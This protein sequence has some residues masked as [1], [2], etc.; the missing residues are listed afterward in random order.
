MRR[1]DKTLIL[2]FTVLLALGTL[3][4]SHPLEVDDAIV[5]FRSLLSDRT[6]HT[7][8]NLRHTLTPLFDG[9]S[10]WYSGI[11]LFVIVIIVLVLRAAHGV[12]L[13]APK[14]LEEAPNIEAEKLFYDGA[15]NLKHGLPAKDIAPQTLKLS[16]LST[17]ENELR[18]KEELLQSWD[19]ELRVLRS[20]VSALINRQSEMV[21]AK[22]RAE[23]MLRAELKN[24]TDLLQSRSKELEALKSKVKTLTEQLTDLRLGKERAE[25]ILQQELKKNAK[26]LQT[27]E[28]AITEL[29]SSLG[30]KQKL[31][32]SRGEELEALKSKVKTLMN[33]LTDLRLDKERAETLLQQELKEKAKI[34]QAKDVAITDLE[35]SLTG[36]LLLQS[37]SN[38]QAELLQIPNREIKTLRSKVNTLT[39]RLAALESAKE[40]AENVLQ[41]QLERKTELLQSKEAASKELEE[42][43]DSRLRVLEGQLTQ[44]EELLKANHAELEALQ[45]KVNN[46]T[47]L[48]SIRERARSLLLQ[49]LHNRSEL[50]QA[51]ESMVKELQE[52][53]SAT[54]HALENARGELEKVVK[55]RTAENRLTGSAPANEQA[56]GLRPLRKGINFRLREL[57]AAKARA[58]A[59]LQPKAKRPSR[60]NDSTIKEP[61]ES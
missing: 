5:R 21:S 6:V 33:Q 2:L 49:E 51:K 52:R 9:T 42:S 16:R 4:L 27:R 55:D 43:L 30:E 15:S 45:S 29:E 58:Q 41:E 26:I 47:E 13:R 48:S 25:N 3:V 59:L 36:K 56:E 14:E 31:L 39:D 24:T 57:G 23:S 46:L 38:E 10:L 1:R 50:L 53:L 32:Q 61:E 44:K 17:L 19:A 18:K 22:A 12:I 35:N 7:V 54:V 28:S 20:R 34:L 37:R 60:A 8:H 40:H 11:V